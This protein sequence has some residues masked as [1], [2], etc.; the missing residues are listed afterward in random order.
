MSVGSLLLGLALLALVAL[1]VARPLTESRFPR[2]QRRTRLQRLTVQKEAIL[3][4]IRALDLDYETGKMP[5]EEYQL[6]R[7][8]FVAEATAI[9]KLI[10]EIEPSSGPVEFAAVAG[11]GTGLEDD[12]EAA[13][14][15]R[16]RVATAVP[17]NG[18]RSHCPQCGQT[19]DP[20]DKFCA[21][22]GHK[23]RQPQNA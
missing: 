12:I 5:E 4:Q 16:R 15:R 21:N 22:C 23:V 8:A 13:I 18:L 20:K 19:L 11:P 10:D 14:S 6:Q 2:R 17:G 7:A 3:I 1:F 9:L